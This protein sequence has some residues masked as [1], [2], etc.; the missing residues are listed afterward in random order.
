M[1]KSFIFII[2]YIKLDRADGLDVSKEKKI[3]EKI[4]KTIKTERNRDQRRSRW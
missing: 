1:L 4:G 2:F 3:V